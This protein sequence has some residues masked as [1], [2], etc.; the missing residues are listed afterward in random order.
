MKN[1]ILVLIIIILIPICC[2]IMNKPKEN[3]VSKEHSSIIVKLTKDNQDLSLDLNNYLIGVV[4]AE[5]PSSFNLE[6][7]KAQAVAS[8]TYALYN[9]YDNSIITNTMEQAYKSNAEL[10]SLWQDKYE[11]YY[12]KIKDAVVSTDNIVMKYDNSLIKSYYYAISN[13]YTE[14][15]MTVFNESLP[16]LNVVDSTFDEDNKNYEVTKT[17]SLQEF[18]NKLNIPVAKLEITDVIKDSSNRVLSLSINNNNFTG[19]NIRK[20]LSLRSTDFTISV[21]DDNVNITTRGYGHGVGMSQ[22]G[23]NYLANKGYNYQDILKYYY[24][25]IEITNY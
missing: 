3:I 21:V 8:R 2:F 15:A 20:S 19:I 10:A 17:M 24:Q 4:G 6:A 13:G 16:Y 22:Y 18:C 7:L 9:N 23:A 25:N 14:D 12:A 11:E 5:M 1:K